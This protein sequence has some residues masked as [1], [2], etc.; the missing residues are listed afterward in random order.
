MVF[1]YTLFIH[2]NKILISLIEGIL[3]SANSLKKGSKGCL[4]DHSAIFYIEAGK[5]NN[6]DWLISGNWA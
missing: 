1:S 3:V 2:P 6:D 5:T 4:T